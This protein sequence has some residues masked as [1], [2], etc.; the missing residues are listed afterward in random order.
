M[1]SRWGRWVKGCGRVEKFNDSGKEVNGGWEDI[2][3]EGI[4]YSVSVGIFL[5]MELRPGVSCKCVIDS[6]V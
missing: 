1:L 2:G 6:F 5:G 4:L 3:G